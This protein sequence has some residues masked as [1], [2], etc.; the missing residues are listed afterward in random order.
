MK[1]QAI[2]SAITLTYLTS[3]A[4]AQI[5]LNANQTY[6]QSF[7]AMGSSLSLPSNWRARYNDSS[8][9]WAENVT[10]VDFQAS[11]GSPTSAGTYNWGTTAGI[12]RAIGVLQAS[13]GSK[14][15]SLIAYF[16]IADAGMTQLH[17]QYDAE[18]YYKNN[19]DMY[20]K[21]FT[22]T[23]GSSWTENVP[24]RVGPFPWSVSPVY[25]FASPWSTTVSTDITLS[26]STPGDLYIQFQ[27]SPFTQG[28][29]VDNISVTV[30]PEPTTI[31]L[32]SVSYTHLTLPT[33][34]SV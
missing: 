24:A 29:G 17:L 22:S 1:L 15:S 4:N 11:S 27:F 5:I 12:D 34:Y 20:V 3:A 26:Q 21:V 13:G 30:V 16:S 32:I 18:Q 23:D 33:I 8:P 7:D 25:T 28:V 31:T 19:A 14:T 9:T 10:T 6:S 2:L